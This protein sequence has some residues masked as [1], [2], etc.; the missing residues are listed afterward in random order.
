M[1]RDLI[2]FGEDWGGH[3]SST[4]H[5]VSR[6]AAD[7]RV[8]WVNSLGLRRPR[9]CARDVARAATKLAS[10]MRPRAPVAKHPVPQGMRVVAPLAVS[11]PGNPAA[12]AINRRLLGTR[13]RR[14]IAE[15]GLSAPILWTSLPTA[16]PL[17][18]EL[19]E[20]AVVYY[21]GDDFGALAGVDHAPV[22]R[23]EEKLAAGADLVI[24]ASEPLAARFAG[25]STLLAPHGVDFDLFA[26][27]AP[28]AKDLPGD[29][30]IAGFYGAL[31]D[32]ID[33]ESLAQAARA[34]PHW[35]FVFVGPV[36]TDVSLLAERPNVRLLGPRPHG[37]LPGYCQHW[38]VSML[39]FRDTAQIRA[40]NPLKLRE[41]LAAGTPLASPRFP[42]MEPYADCIAV[43]E[44]GADLAG[45]LE[46]AALDTDRNLIRRNKVAGESWSARAAAISQA[47]EAL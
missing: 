29:S 23:M 25:R 33:V 15:N 42:A 26:T 16:L 39:P 3:P 36:Q 20:S 6:L 27:P 7:R 30:P 14:A 40:C 13:L 34:L 12:D 18:G 41:Y 24:A 5:I 38:N 31:A 28:R 11:W 17:V 9:L 19:G 21:C 47:L 8:L 32:W 22:S 4:Q 43:Y 35:T 37:E 10:A 46:R 44:A 2:V 1:A 45:A